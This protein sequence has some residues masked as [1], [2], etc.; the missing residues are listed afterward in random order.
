MIRYETDIQIEEA[1]GRGGR[2][3]GRQRFPIS[4]K[5]SR[6]G[7]EA[8]SILDGVDRETASIRVGH[9]LQVQSRNYV[10]NDEIRA[11]KIL[12]INI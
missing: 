10:K 5:A 6:E 12:W 4:A 1:W 7:G 11:E 3:D 8:Y 2:V 9:S